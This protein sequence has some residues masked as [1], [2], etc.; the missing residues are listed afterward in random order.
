M[1]PTEAPADAR[2]AARPEYGAWAPDGL[3]AA[4]VSSSD[5]AI[6]S[7]SLD[8]I[9]TSWNKAAERLYGYT[10]EE[11]I[12]RHINL[13]AVPGRESEMA[14]IIERI[15]RG[16]RVEHF[17]TERRRKDG[18]AVEISLTVSPVYDKEG[19]IVGASKI[20]RDF[21]ERRRTEKRINLL[22]SELD[23][24]A[25]NM[26]AVAQ[27]I[28]RL[29]RAETLSDFV[30]AV[31]GRLGALAR[32]HSQV[33]ENRWDGAELGRLAAEILETFGDKEGRVA[34]D[35]PR[36]YVSPEGAQV[37]GVLLH[38]LA[39][40]AVKHGSLSVPGGT[41]ALGWEIQAD[42]S[43]KLTW[44]EQG[45]PKVSPPTRR[46]FG[47]RVIERNVADQLGGTAAVR[48][49]PEGLACEFTVPA[50]HLMPPPLP[51]SAPRSFSPDPTGRR[52][53]RFAG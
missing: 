10:A 15:R 4:I 53:K 18:V 42:G 5:D 48:W 21:T 6:I 46:S 3:L 39:T 50:A 11:A 7:K 8:G 24:R 23:H 25:K 41:V 33:A 31:D 52:Q 45:G 12:G 38:E 1:E 30:A 37:L 40:N 20:A 51:S 32:V 13:I 19:R 34:I 35:G 44:V 28:I 22:M 2:A 47:S 16:E 43:L 14:A 26:L 27:A 29:T 9:I 36:A 17:E 49:L